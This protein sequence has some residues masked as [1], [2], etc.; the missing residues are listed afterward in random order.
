MPSGQNLYFP[1]KRRGYDFPEDIGKREDGKL[2]VLI[3]GEDIGVAVFCQDLFQNNDAKSAS[4][5]SRI[6]RTFCSR[7]SV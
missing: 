1:S 6:F 4:V 5:V 3:S 7:Q 2:A